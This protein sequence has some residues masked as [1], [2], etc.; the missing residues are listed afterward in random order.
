MADVDIVLATYNGEK[1]LSQQ[2]DSIIAQKYKDWR[3]LISDDGSTDNTLS[4]IGKYTKSDPRIVLVNNIRQGGVVKNFSKA[5][6]FVS[7]KYIMF[8]D[9]DD[10]W[11][12]EKIEYSKAI[13]EKNQEK[14]G[15]IPILV[16]SDLVVVDKEL[17]VIRKSFFND[18]PGM[19]PEYNFDKRFLLWRSTVYGC[20]VMFNKALYDKA[21][22]FSNEIT[23]HDQWFAL[24]ALLNGKIVYS[25]VSHIYYRQHDSNVVGAKDRNLLN[26]IIR[27]FISIRSIKSA[28]QL[29]FKTVVRLYGKKELNYINKFYFIINNVLPYVHAAKIYSIFFIFFYL[30]CKENTRE[31]LLY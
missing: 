17:N 16:F 10:Y 6:E 2:L 30:K 1:Y 23:M 25:N 3:L 29:T 27:L 9:Q 11:M 4:I 12:P 7:S 18:T 5:L 21:T 22:P 31:N 19:N 28:A 24:M 20:T 15:N 26:R 14:Y 8:C 13:L